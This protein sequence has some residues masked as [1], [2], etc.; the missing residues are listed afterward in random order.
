MLAISFSAC[1][2]EQEKTVKKESIN[3]NT[4]DKT[5]FPNKRSELAILMRSMQDEL[6]AK[7]SEIAKGDFPNYSLV[8]K[9]GS[10]KTATPT[11]SKDSGPVFQAFAEKFLTDMKSFEEAPPENK[12]EI[13]NA[14]VQSC[15]D[16]H[17]EHCHGPMVAIRKLKL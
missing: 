13:F 12:V 5:R 3:E 1:N 8:E 16:C 6:M 4:T 14:M 11:D 7:K 2:S 17:Q 9:F 10:I 15:L